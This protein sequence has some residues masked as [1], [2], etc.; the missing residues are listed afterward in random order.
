MYTR[1]SQLKV[2]RASTPSTAGAI[3]Y[4]VLT[5]TQAPRFPVGTRGVL[6]ED[7]DSEAQTLFIISG[8]AAGDQRNG[9]RVLEYAK[10]VTAVIRP[11]GSQA[12]GDRI[13]VKVERTWPSGWRCRVLLQVSQR[14]D[15]FALSFHRRFYYEKL[16][17][18][19]Q[20]Q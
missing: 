5:L 3:P 18:S 2:A 1:G 20:P 19:V 4:Q 15:C 16:I 9:W 8:E 10:D 14:Q 11:R 17:T 13:I 6:N 12:S 7:H